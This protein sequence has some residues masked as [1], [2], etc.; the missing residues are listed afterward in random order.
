MKHASGLKIH[1]PSC[2]PSVREAGPTQSMLAE[3]IGPVLQHVVRSL[4][5]LCAFAAKYQN[6]LRFK[7]SAY[8]SMKI[9]MLSLFFSTVLILGLATSPQG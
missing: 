4:D 7:S 2:Q 3:C 8:K 1:H 9:R 5:G 6:R